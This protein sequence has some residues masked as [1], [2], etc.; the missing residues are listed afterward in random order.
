M[1]KVR[2]IAFYLPQFHP[3]PE[4]DEWWGKGFTEWT[5]VAQSKKLFPGHYQPHIPADLGFY[6]LRVPEVREKQAEMA[7]EYGVEGFC[8]WHYWFGG[9]KQLLERPFNEVLSSGK[10]DFPFC[11]GW[12][13]HTWEKKLWDKNGNS[14]VLIEQ[15]Y[16]GESDDIKHFYTLLPAFKDHRYI[17]VNG[18]CFFIVHNIITNL[19]AIKS[20]IKTWK[21]LADENGLEGFYFVAQDFESRTK[22]ELLEAGFDAV[23]NNDTLNIHHHL[24][25][26]QKVILMILR[27]CFHFPSI[28]SYKKAIKYMLPKDCESRSAIPVIAPNWDH[29]PRTGGKALIL[30]NSKPK[31]FYNLAKK[32]IEMVKNKPEEERIIIL[33]SWNEWG[34]GNHMEPDKKFGTQYLEM[35]RKA[36]NESE[37]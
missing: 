20:F 13:N 35:L 19:P 29:S 8:Y 2:I 12:A 3:I 18:K 28:F 11:L 24:T 27:N 32:A 21:R 34:E 25:I 1:S 15:Q 10:P 23:Y 5:C 26:F 31:Y 7:K 33:K 30:H 6:D 4:N 17:K 37:R 16:L 22:K 14:K 36:L 9:G